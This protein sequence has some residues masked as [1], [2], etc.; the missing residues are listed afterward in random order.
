ME[1]T[2][3]NELKLKVDY[4][5]N[6]V[7]NLVDQEDEILTEEDRLDIRK[8]WK[9]YEEGKTISAEKLWGDLDL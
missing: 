5:T 1:Q 9:E 7:E 8:S 3:L 2:S 4:L 6:L